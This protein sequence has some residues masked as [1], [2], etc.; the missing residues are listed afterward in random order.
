MYI[1]KEWNGEESEIFS[2]KTNLSFFFFFRTTMNKI[3]DKEYDFSMKI[4]ITKRTDDDR[5]KVASMKASMKRKNYLWSERSLSL[6]FASSLTVYTPC[7][8]AES[9]KKKK[10]YIKYIHIYARLNNFLFLNIA[11]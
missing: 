8:R 10:E 4:D 5:I 7:R 2:S 6:S 3:E 11:L 1:K 9:I